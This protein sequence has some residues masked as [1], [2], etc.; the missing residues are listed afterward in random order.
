MNAYVTAILNW[1]GIFWDLAHCV[2]VNRRFGGR[3]NFHLHAL[4]STEQETSLQQ[5]ARQNSAYI[6]VV[7]LIT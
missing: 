3:Y 1:F 6:E 2:Y 7:C 4:K 5:V